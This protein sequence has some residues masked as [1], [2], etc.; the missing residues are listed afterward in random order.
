M[1]VFKKLK[2]MI[3]TCMCMKVGLKNP[4]MGQTVELGQ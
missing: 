2:M 3:A 4:I 1:K